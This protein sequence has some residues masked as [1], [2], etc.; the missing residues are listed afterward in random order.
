MK[1][2]KYLFDICF[3]TDCPLPLLEEVERFT[4]YVTKDKSLKCHGNCKH[5]VRW[6]YNKSLNS[7]VGSCEEN[8]M[9][10]ANH[11][12]CDDFEEI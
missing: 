10:L 8:G 7:D 5:W 12:A 2:R 3:E 9:N 4:R 11:M 6:H 1:L